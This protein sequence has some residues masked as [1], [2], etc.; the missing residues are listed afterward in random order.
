M[1]YCDYIE[2]DKGFQTSVN[3]ELDLNKVEKIRGYIP[4]E[5]SVKVLGA[6]LRSFYYNNES[7]RR[8]S[9]LMG[10]YG[11]GKSHLL[12]VLTAITS[13]DICGA[14]GLSKNEARQ[15]Q[16][17]LCDK[18][19]SV[20]FE[21]GALAKAIVDANTRALPVIINSNTGDIN[22]AF[23]AAIYS[24]LTSS[25][26]QSLLPTT[27]FDSAAATIDRWRESFPKAFSKLSAELKKSKRTTDDLYIGLGQFDRSSYD[28]FC[29]IYPS[30]TAGTEFNPLSNMDVVKLYLSVANALC[31][32]TEYSGI[33]IIFDEFSKF[34]EANLD[35]SKMLNFKIIQDMAEAATRSSKCQIHLT[36]VTHKDIL[37]YSTSDSFKTVEGRFEKVQFVASSEQS[38][39]LIANAIVKKPDFAILLR[40]HAE[41]F[42]KVAND[43][44]IVNVF[45]DLDSDIFENKLVRGC[46]PLSPLSAFALLHISEIVGQNE[47][48]LFTFLARDDENTLGAFIREEYSDFTVLTVDYI[49]SYFEDLFK[50]E[51]FNAS[52]HSV[53]SKTRAAL[54]QTA[55]KNEIKILK[56][57]AVIQIISDERFKATPIHIKAALMMDHADFELAIRSLLK[58]HILSQR[59]SSEYVLLTANGVDIQNSIDSYVKTKISKVSF[60]EVLDETC[61]LGYVMP[62]EYNDRFSMLR[63]FKKIYMD[64][65]VFLKYK[66]A[67]QIL[68]DFPYDGLIV[69]LLETHKEDTEAIL[70]KI[71][72]F[73][74]APQV[75]LCM[76]KLT[77]SHEHL[78]KK[79]IAIK[80]LNIEAAQFNDPHYSEEVEIFEEDIKR[81]ICTAIDQMYAPN[82]E[83]SYFVNCSG[84]LD[85][86]RQVELNHEVSRICGEC[87]CQ[88][89]VINNEMVNKHVL[90]AQNLKGR[91]IAIDWILAHS[92]DA[93]IPCMDGYG[94]E[95]SIFK[96]F[97]KSTGLDGHQ[98]VEDAALLEVLNIIREFITGCEHRKNNFAPL[99]QRLTSMPFGIRKG[100]LPLFIAYAMR[101]Y[102]QN[103]VLYFK[104]K[105]VELSSAVLNSLN[106]APENYELLVEAGTDARERFLNSLAKMFEGYIAFEGTST[107]QI[108]STVKGMQ[109][110]IRALPEFTKKY[111]TYY[112]DSEVKQVDDAV[113]IIRNELLKFE[114]NSRELL[115]TIW[116]E[117]LDENGDLEACATAIAT[118]KQQLDTHISN[119]R[120]ELMVRVTEMFMPGYQGGLS[121]SVIAWYKSLP[122]TTRHHV[123]DSNTN[124]L[125]SMANAVSSYDN[126]KLLDSLVMAF[127]SIAIED[128]SDSLAAKFEEDLSL[129][130][131]TINNYREVAAEGSQTFKLL[132]DFAEEKIEKT[133]STSR[134]SPLGETVLTN[135]RSVFE[136]YNGAIDPD[137]QLAIITKLIGDIVQ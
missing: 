105:E 136:E 34:L 115:F 19:S 51:V 98:R 100:I 28:L 111:K 108:Y 103:I 3:L 32:Q 104:G 88:T 55:E 101:P 97:F 114:I 102:K 132:I 90:N 80:N 1:K 131:G 30:I 56:A 93:L 17:E 71:K 44:A 18:I 40:E 54:L 109:A 89:P 95:V 116:P 60:C 130:I 62:R 78:L 113:N 118:V 2:L 122:E 50:K 65:S 77:F 46:F 137:E 82:S 69:H 12:L 31:E 58:R 35:K 92:D 37:D 135:L 73:T 85:V 91:S 121:H 20:N 72:S 27:Y 49:Y 15:I 23:L 45:N 61:E 21:V 24:S 41:G 126:D 8:A 96:S 79:A 75:I 11:R 4:T 112:I 6:L 83:N 10:P 67:Q 107:N 68:S 42:S 117:H 43:S 120:I 110:W 87:Y 119:Y 36:C 57:I 125:L 25:N 47:R 94:A 48:S 33:N 127:T 5:Q 123:F 64:A 133:F 84:H 99:Y 16:N 129:A 70:K 7:T 13:L 26:L 22:Q 14:S 134:I 29:K 124:S 59:E 9:V 106:D 86:T 38:Y 128:W 74:S 39:E 66:N 53:W 76:S 81:Q 63:Y 52:V